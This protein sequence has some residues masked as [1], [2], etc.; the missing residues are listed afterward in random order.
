MEGLRLNY[1][2]E[3]EPEE[4]KDI[5]GFNELA[6]GYYK[7]EDPKLVPTYTELIAA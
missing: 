2:A 1:K 7:I 6:Q 3:S 5:F 4:V